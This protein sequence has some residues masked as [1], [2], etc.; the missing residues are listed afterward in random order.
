MNAMSSGT[1][2]VAAPASKAARVLM[3]TQYLGIGG[4]ERM[5][6]NLSM[7]LKR[8]GEWAPSVFVYDDSYRDRMASLEDVFTRNDVAVENFRKP[9]GFS[10]A[11]VESIAR[12]AREQ[13]IDAIH[14]HDLGALI[15]GALAKLRL[16]GRVKLIHTQH[17]FVHLAKNRRYRL[18]E[19]FFTL[20]VDRLIVVSGDTRDRYVE[21]GVDPAKIK[22]IQN[23]V[24]FAEE[25]TLSRSEKL[26]RRG[27]CIET[28][29]KDLESAKA[30]LSA[31][32]NS[33]WILYLA[34]VHGG[35]GQIEALDLWNALP[36][37]VRSRST[38]VFVGP[39]TQ[40]GALAALH[41][42][43]ESS[44]T[45]ENIVYAGSTQN[46]RQWLD[47]ADLF[48][49]SSVFEGMPLA[50]NEAVGSGLPVVLSQ[51]AGHVS[52]EKFA[53]LYSLENP[54]QGAKAV[55]SALDALNADYRQ[56]SLSLWSRSEPIRTKL[57]TRA[58]ALEYIGAYHRR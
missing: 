29:T 1:T 30:A 48:L 58:M 56:A 2:S 15:Y 3:L 23:G 20:F 8:Q 19:R 17:S 10:W 25:P 37:A 27:A 33:Q 7:G 41:S 57:S 39:E 21:L 34:R 16:W 52:L 45:R 14:S 43:I 5:I 50:P 31:Q 54:E 13:N 49:S 24:D 44:K 51:I 35:K 22:V 18:Y 28:L 53:D 36:E 12:Y 47:C 42:K 32:Q 9:P 26:N 46:P 6:F 38:L 40:T 4:L 11:A 55:A